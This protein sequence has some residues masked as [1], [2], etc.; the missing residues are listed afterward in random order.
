[1][2]SEHDVNGEEGHLHF[3]LAA[4]LGRK[5]SGSDLLACAI[6]SDEVHLK[7]LLFNYKSSN[8]RYYLTAIDYGNY[9]Q[10][11]RNSSSIYRD[12]MTREQDA[13]DQP[14]RARHA[15]PDRCAFKSKNNEANSN[16]VLAASDTATDRLDCRGRRGL[17]VKRRRGRGGATQSTC[18]SAI[19][20][21]S[22]D[23]SVVQWKADRRLRQLEGSCLGQVAQAD[24]QGDQRPR[25]RVH[26]RP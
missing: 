17:L 18:A 12:L 5:G 4:V 21:T 15:V 25:W 6:D 14:S 2:I 20:D 13:L 26:L 16:D 9:R 10:Q 8:E 23:D 22:E 11:Q 19:V 1:M 7:S 24:P 3:S